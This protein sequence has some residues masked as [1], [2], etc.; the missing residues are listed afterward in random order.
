[1]CILN[2]SL[3][4]T[5]FFYKLFYAKLGLER[6]YL[7]NLIIWRLQDDACARLLKLCVC[8][9]QKKTDTASNRGKYQRKL[10]MPCNRSIHFQNINFDH[11]ASLHAPFFARY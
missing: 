6:L 5:V 11:S 7:G 10:I 9:W 2:F 3:K 1:M 4:S 8:F